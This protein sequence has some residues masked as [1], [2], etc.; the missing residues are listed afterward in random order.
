[1]RLQSRTLKPPSMY[2]RRHS[3]LIQGNLLL[4]F[5]DFLNSDTLFRSS[6]VNF[7]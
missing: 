4:F 3:D 7:P 5:V 6:A 1:M 2:T